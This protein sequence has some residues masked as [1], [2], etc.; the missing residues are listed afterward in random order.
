LRELRR[1]MGCWTGACPTCGRSL[2]SFTLY[3][4]A[5]P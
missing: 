1:L 3:L 5:P 4:H 2:P